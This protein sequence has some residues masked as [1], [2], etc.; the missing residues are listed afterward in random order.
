MC[1]QSYHYTHL[2]G[3]KLMTK[4]AIRHTE[5]NSLAKIFL[6]Y[7]SRFSHKAIKQYAGWRVTTS[8]RGMLGVEK[9]TTSLI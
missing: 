8:D 9:E 1:T 7:P 6:L 5:V 2:F 3:L 4:R